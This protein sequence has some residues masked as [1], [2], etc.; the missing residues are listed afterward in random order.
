MVV[1]TMVDG[2]SE[3]SGE[4]LQLDPS[5][6]KWEKCTL[7]VKGGELRISGAKS[8]IVL[9]V[10]QLNVSLAWGKKN[11]FVIRQTAFGSGQSENIQL[12]GEDAS[13]WVQFLCETQAVHSEKADRINIARQ[14]NRPKGV[15][16]SYE[17]RFEEEEIGVHCCIKQSKSQPSRQRFYV[18]S[19]LSQSVSHV[20][21]VREGDAILNV[22]GF[23]LT[24]LSPNEA[25]LVFLRELKKRPISLTFELTE[26]P[27]KLVKQLSRQPPQET[28]L[29]EPNF[30]ASMP[31]HVPNSQV[32]PPPVEEAEES[33][34]KVDAVGRQPQIPTSH[35]QKHQTL[36]RFAK[37]MTSNVH[38]MRSIDLFRGLD[39]NRSGKITRQEFQAGL[40]RLGLGEWAKEEIRELL[41]AFDVDGDGEISVK[42][43]KEGLARYEEQK[44]GRNSAEKMTR[45][46]DRKEQAHK[47]MYEMTSAALR[48]GKEYKDKST[49]SVHK[50][51]L[52]EELKVIDSALLREKIAVERITGAVGGAVR[53]SGAGSGPELD[54][55]FEFE[56]GA[57]TPHPGNSNTILGMST[58]RTIRP[59]QHDEQKIVG[60]PLQLRFAVGEGTQEGMQ[61]K[62]A[63]EED[64]RSIE[65]LETE[66]QTQLAAD[67]ALDK[68][69]TW[70]QSFMGRPHGLG[71]E[72]G[73]CGG[74]NGHY[75]NNSPYAHLSQNLSS[76]QLLTKTLAKTVW[77]SGAVSAGGNRSSSSQRA[78]PTT[79]RNKKQR[80]RSAPAR[81]VPT[82]IKT[83]AQGNC[84]ER[85]IE[86]KTRKKVKGR[87]RGSSSGRGRGTK[88]G[89]KGG[90]RRSYV[91]SGAEG[92]GNTGTLS[93]GGGLIDMPSSTGNHVE[94]GH[95]GAT[96]EYDSEDSDE[97]DNS[98]A[99]GA[100]AGEGVGDAGAV[101]EDAFSRVVSSLKADQQVEAQARQ[102]L[103]AKLRGAHL[104]GCQHQIVQQH[105]QMMMQPPQVPAG[106]GAGRPDPA[107]SSTVPGVFEGVLELVRYQ[108]EVAK[109]EA[110]HAWEQ[111]AENISRQVRL[112]LTAAD[113][114]EVLDNSVVDQDSVASGVRNYGGGVQLR[115]CYSNLLRNRSAAAQR[116]GSSASSTDAAPSQEVDN[117]K[118]ASTPNVTTSA[119]AA[120]N[121]NRHSKDG[122][123][124]SI[125]GEMT[126]VT[127]GQ[128]SQKELVQLG[129][130]GRLAA[131]HTI[132]V[133]R[134]RMAGSY[135]KKM[136]LD[137]VMSD[138][139]LASRS[140]S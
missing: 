94:G 83:P 91:W 120:T 53:G 51:M 102:A 30:R 139:H 130:Q 134:D 20:A 132:Q 35:A 135:K 103:G 74:N 82:P 106:A 15:A 17:L 113:L 124:R 80:A 96:F 6:G 64:A 88:R 121:A 54:A 2:Q 5:S 36:E 39:L 77:G 114:N 85:G 21:G 140:I 32:D 50:S 119:A 110:A 69:Y 63:L 61:G 109:T 37:A 87:G 126:L 118:F 33:Q 52:H 92:R 3:Q 23:D 31:A 108:Q 40:T 72:S 43:L 24:G 90:R 12:K 19:V 57:S 86:R 16:N 70:H 11:S 131:R 25:K 116:G 75:N 67:A 129:H 136:N 55:T 13:E 1:N 4:C 95:L 9:N 60:T 62:S 117:R 46:A 48:A 111:H 93:V 38:R 68:R 8:E 26:D 123:R 105:I 66:L 84:T 42:E 29:E 79:D 125:V 89:V 76:R 44:Q 47:R 59:A 56:T 99:D 112:Q 10:A 98:R 100:N 49:H 115:E 127:T 65:E 28:A 22:N 122:R 101:D 18:K 58:I 41:D 73:Q 71:G 14:G 45:E 137:L 97:A 78:T 133:R 27:E 81:E 138:N 107:D 128:H 104:K 7:R 34:L